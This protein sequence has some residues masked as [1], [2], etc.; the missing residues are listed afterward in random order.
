MASLVE[1]RL[2][3]LHSGR[4]VGPLFVHGEWG[5]GKSHTLSFIRF[6][7]CQRAIASSAV[8]LNARSFALNFPQ[9]FYSMLVANIRCSENQSGLRE[10]LSNWLGEQSTRE[11]LSD[12]AQAPAAVDL[13]WPLKALV[14][15]Y[16]GENLTLNDAEW[17]WTKLLGGDLGWA[18]Y[19]YKRSQALA[20]IQSIA[21]MV[22][23]L[24]FA[25]LVVTFDEAE[26]ID[27][28]WNVSSRLVAYEV[29]GRFSEM[30]S[31]WCVF[32]ITDRFKHIVEVD[33]SRNV[34]SWPQTSEH[35]RR[36]LRAWSSNQYEIVS[37]PLI[38]SVLANT[39]AANVIRI[40]RDAHS[41]GIVDG[42]FLRRCI[43]EWNRNP[44]RNPRRLI[45]LIVHGLDV[46]HQPV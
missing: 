15:V 41:N 28:L 44:S 35:A 42:V 3:S 39:L 2:D 37:P 27:Q 16:S 22:R 19:V 32:G 11:R 46:S 17:A 38:N 20:R 5:T 18:D 21:R 30:P 14:S 33:L 40:Y 1:H 25:G 12:F 26:T 8:Q 7:A 34:L 36:F 6:M 45:R 13:D 4:P 10:L 24:G 31:V 29:L 23:R 9:R 43:D